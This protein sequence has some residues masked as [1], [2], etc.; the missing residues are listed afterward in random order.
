VATQF[1][2]DIRLD[3]YCGAGAPRFNLTAT[4]GFHFIG[5]CSNGTVSAPFLDR[6][7]RQWVHV[8]FDPQNPGQA[9][10]V[11]APGAKIIS[12][13]I[14]VDEDTRGSAAGASVVDNV[15]VNGANVGKPGN[16]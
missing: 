14:I 5:G 2:F 8:T 3:G 11:V 6:Q 15:N 9:F 13:S 4:D 10:P 16:N 7:G 12:L 1:G